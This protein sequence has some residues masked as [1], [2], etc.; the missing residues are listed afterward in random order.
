[1]TVKTSPAA[2]EL[3]CR[4]FSFP[5]NQIPVEIDLDNTLLPECL[6][7]ICQDACQELFF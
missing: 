5:V 3:K 2:G 4:D 1:V 7:W 6:E